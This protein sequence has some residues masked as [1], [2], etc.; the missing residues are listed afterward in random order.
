MEID[1]WNLARAI[2]EKMVHTMTLI[3]SRY[4]KYFRCRTR[5]PLAPGRLMGYR[6]KLGVKMKNISWMKLLINQ[7][8][9]LMYTLFH[10]TLE[11]GVS[12]PHKTACPKKYEPTYWGRR[13]SVRRLHLFQPN[14]TYFIQMSPRDRKLV[15]VILRNWRILS[16]PCQIFTNMVLKSDEIFS[17]SNSKFRS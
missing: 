15:R 5:F 16:H 9:N 10:R 8:L 4:L 17:N 11:R 6:V 13:I 12:Q 1:R 7:F 14:F 3:L 2:A